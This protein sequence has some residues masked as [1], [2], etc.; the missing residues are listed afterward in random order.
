MSFADNVSFLKALTVLLSASTALV[1][2]STS[3]EIVSKVVND[4]F[5]VALFDWIKDKIITY[6]SEW[7]MISVVDSKSKK[8]EEIVQRSWYPFGSLLS[9]IE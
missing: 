5:I 6:E 3:M 9:A 1:L 8:S 4:S 7:K 2:A